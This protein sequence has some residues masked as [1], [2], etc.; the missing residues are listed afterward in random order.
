[1]DPDIGCRVKRLLFRVAINCH[2]HREANGPASN[3]N[4]CHC[5][6]GIITCYS[7]IVRLFPV[8]GSA[9]TFCLGRLNG[10]FAFACFF[11]VESRDCE[12]ESK[13]RDVRLRA[14]VSKTPKLTRTTCARV[15]ERWCRLLK[16]AIALVSSLLQSPMTRQPL[17][18]K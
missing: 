18:K 11:S 6:I 12:S 9:R 14:S 1:M 7:R 17:C 16:I 4:G 8:R 5:Q 3:G 13:T 2:V 15:A 10:A